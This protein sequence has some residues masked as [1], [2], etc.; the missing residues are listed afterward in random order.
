M[1]SLE[2]DSSPQS[3]TEPEE[4]R[5]D[6]PRRRVSLSG[7]ANHVV[8]VLGAQWGDEGKGKLVD[9]L[10]RDAHVCARFNG[11]S[12]AGH[13][14]HVEG[15]KYA[16]H[17]LPCGLLYSGVKNLIGNGVVVHLK[18][19]LEEL[20]QLKDSDPQAI[21]RLFISNRAQLLFDFHQTVD[22]LYEAEKTKDGNQ[23]G[24]T[25]KGIGPCYSNKAA[26]SG[27]RVGDLLY[28]DTFVERYTR[29]LNEYKKRFSF[30][31]D[32]EEELARHKKYLETIKGQITDSVYFMKES[33]D[34]GEKVLVEGANATMLDIDFGTYP[35]VTSS[36]TVAGGICIGLGIPPTQIDCCI[37]VVKAYTTRV[38]SGPFPTELHDEIGKHLQEV[39]SE[40]GTTTG[41]RRR[42]G[43]LDMVMLRYSQ[44]MNGF[45]SVNLTK[46]D[47]LTGIDQ[48]KIAV[49]YKLPDGTVLPEGY[50]P[51]VLE[52]LASV[53]VVY[54]TMSGWTEDISQMTTFD[55]LPK[56]AQDYVVRIETL[57]KVPISWVGVG[58]DR[59]N[60]IRL[61][62]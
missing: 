48:L 23:I 53:E 5:R 7:M 18:T 47:V 21:T 1:T 55:Q 46:L 36:S 42:C 32:A 52:E 38:G 11:G 28:W 22:G 9:I 61:R 17:L 43:W 31:H 60:T 59:L 4:V 14:L 12:N 24:T 8:A 58:P 34:R 27:V 37:G 16:L 10:A 26:R 20:E 41:R 40:F 25:K 51:A 33:L 57:M 30:E 44:C 19:L 3:L 2:K 39:G 62:P 49:A 6:A 50:F 29:L 13:T 54:E 56:A 35:F 15:K 45:H